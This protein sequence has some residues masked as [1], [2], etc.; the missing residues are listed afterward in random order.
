MLPSSKLSLASMIVACVVLVGCGDEVSGPETDAVRTAD[1]S[2]NAHAD[3]AE[4]ATLSEQ[5]NAVRAATKKYR[6]ASAAL[7]DGYVVISP[8]VPGMGFHFSDRNPPFGTEREDPPVLVYFPNG[9][10]DP[11]PGEALDPERVDDLILGAVEY[12]VAGD[13]ETD[14]PN[15]FADE[16]SPRRLATTE[17]EGWHFEDEEGFTGLHAWVHRG[18]PAGVFHTTNP[19]IE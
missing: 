1:R 10:Y 14:P 2:A 4:Q 3:R 12:L 7:D 8:Y 5:L 11:A 13:Q 9:S 19:T 17:E 6:H 16:D 15:I 18:N